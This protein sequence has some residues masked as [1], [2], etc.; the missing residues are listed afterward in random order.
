[1]PVRGGAPLVQKLSDDSGNPARPGFARS[2]SKRPADCDFLQRFEQSV[3]DEAT[4]ATTLRQ[5]IT[6]VAGNYVTAQLDSL[7]KYGDAEAYYRFVEAPCRMKER[8]ADEQG[9]MYVITSRPITCD[10]FRR[11]LSGSRYVYRLID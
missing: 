7:L 6:P 8:I 9:A 11:V 10:G 4:D 1:M 2:N 5:T 3:G